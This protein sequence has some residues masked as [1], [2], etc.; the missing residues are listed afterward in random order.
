MLKFFKF[1][2]I[3]LREGER[4]RGGEKHRLVVPLTYTFIGCFL[5]VP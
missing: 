5:Y 1:L 3:A 4:E 2:F